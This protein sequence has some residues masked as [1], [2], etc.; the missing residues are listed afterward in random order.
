MLSYHDLQP[1]AD[2]ANS[3]AKRSQRVFDLLTAA[4]NETADAP[5][6]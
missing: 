2:N 1:P 6:C 4:N 5:I 3:A